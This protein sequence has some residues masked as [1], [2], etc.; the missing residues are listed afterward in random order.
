M[1]INCSGYTG[2]QLGAAAHFFFA[3]S[4]AEPGHNQNNCSGLP[5]RGPG[6]AGLNRASGRAS[7]FGL[8]GRAAQQLLII[9]SCYHGYHMILFF[10]N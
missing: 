7:G 9:C 5:G 2:L 8:R 4:P 10:V 3:Q 6:S 1:D